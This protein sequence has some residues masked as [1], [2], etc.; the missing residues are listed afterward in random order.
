MAVYFSFRLRMA[1]LYFRPLHKKLLFSL[2]KLPMKD[3]QGEPYSQLGN[4][5]LF[6]LYF[7]IGAVVIARKRNV[8][9]RLVIF[10]NF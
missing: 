1:G 7:C 6:Q 8:P 4:I 3:V 2:W 5:K 10:K 9:F